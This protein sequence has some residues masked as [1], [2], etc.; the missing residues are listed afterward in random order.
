MPVTNI[1][2]GGMWASSG[3]THQISIT[4]ARPGGRGWAY[5]ET[6]LARVS[7]VGAADTWISGFRYQPSH[8]QI[9]NAIFPDPAG[10]PSAR[11]ISD[12]LSVTF[13]V[14]VNNKYAYAIGKVSSWD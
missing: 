14:R 13:T 12:C 4:V 2:S 6:M 1:A 8:D 11:W 5:A 3:G 9:F 7:G 10:A